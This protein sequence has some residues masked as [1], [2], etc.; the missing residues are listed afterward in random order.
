VGF[1]TPGDSLFTDHDWLLNGNDSIWPASPLEDPSQP[2]A[3]NMPTAQNIALS[4]FPSQPLSVENV[5]CTT[6][7]MCPSSPPEPPTPDDPWP[8]EL[9]AGPSHQVIVLPPLGDAVRNNSPSRH[10]ATPPITASVWTSLQNLIRLPATCHPFQSVDLEAFPNKETLDYCIDRYF[11]R[12]HQVSCAADQAFSVW[13]ML[14]FIFSL[15]LRLGNAHHTPA[16][17]PSG[18]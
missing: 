16:D 13:S 8:V 6:T 17:I 15:C 3:L 5:S 12:F 7:L 18:R 1:Q 10:F 14:T 9:H 4:G 11:L 2:H